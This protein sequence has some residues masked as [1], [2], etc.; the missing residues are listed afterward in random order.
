MV[1]GA[2]DGNCAT[3]SLVMEI[4]PAMI[5]KIAITQAKIGLWMKNFDMGRAYYLASWPLPALSEGVAGCSGSVGPAAVGAKPLSEKAV[6]KK[7]VSP[8]Q[9]SEVKEV[10][11]VA[12]ASPLQPGVSYT[13]QLITLS[14]ETSAKGFID[15]H[16]LGNNAR[17]QRV[18]SGEKELFV[19]SYGQYT[20][21]ELANRALQT[22]KLQ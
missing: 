18:K 21:R 3:G 1:G 11:K 20:T 2:T 6:I 22:L 16:A 7:P 5:T 14:S 9:I 12:M 10:K 15:S 8:S 13:L 4:T 19:V 17:Y